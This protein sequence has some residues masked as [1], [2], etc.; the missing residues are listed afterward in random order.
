MLG[1]K[2]YQ[3]IVTEIEKLET[4]HADGKIN[5][6]IAMRL[7]HMYIVKHEYDKENEVGEIELITKQN[8]HFYNQNVTDAIFYGTPTKAKESKTGDSEFMSLAYEHGHDKVLYAVN[9]YLDHARQW[10]PVE[11]ARIMDCIK[12]KCKY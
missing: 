5:Y 10:N 3:E 7:A 4:Q 1:K 2:D 11:Y 9:E 6:D 8:E 12:D